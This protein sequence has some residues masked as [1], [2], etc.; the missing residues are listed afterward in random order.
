MAERGW[1]ISRKGVL[2]SELPASLFTV[3]VC[4]YLLCG[5]CNSRRIES[6]MLEHAQNKLR[7]KQL[8]TGVYVYGRE[9]H[10]SNET[11]TFKHYRCTFT[12]TLRSL[13]HWWCW[14]EKLTQ[15]LKSFNRFG[16][17]VRQC[18]MHHQN[19]D[20]NNISELHVEEDYQWIWLQSFSVFLTQ[21]YI[22][23]L[24]TLGSI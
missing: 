18:T 20:T 12:C 16:A 10:I 8:C 4:C 17:T 5:W 21:S 7:P 3:R 14:E 22:V 6:G 2:H 24:T 9:K 11:W 15:K 23:F 13:P 19:M 1:E